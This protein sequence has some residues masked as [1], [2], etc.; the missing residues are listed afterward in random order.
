DKGYLFSMHEPRDA[1]TWLVAFDNP[2]DKATLRWEITVDDDLTAVANGN[3]IEMN[4][5][6]NNKNKW[7]FE[8]DQ[9]I[10]TYLMALD[11]GDYET[12]E[13]Q[14]TTGIPITHYIE[15]GTLDRANDTF[16][17]TP[18]VIDFFSDLFAEYPFDRYGNAVVPLGGLAM[19]HTTITSFGRPLVGDPDGALIN[20]HEIGHHW[21]GNW[22]TLSEWP[23][24]WLNE[25]FTSYSEVL[26]WEHLHGEEGRLEYLDYQRLVYM[27]EKEDEGTYP[28]YDPDDLFG[29][30]IYEKGSLVVDML[31]VVMGD[32][33]FFTTLRDWM[34]EYGGQNASTP[35][36]QALA[37]VEYGHSLDWFFDQWVYG[38]GQPSY[39]W[40]VSE[41]TIADGTVQLDFAI[42][43]TGNELFAMPMEL[44]WTDE[45]YETVTE[46]VWVS[47]AEQTFSF[48][49]TGNTS[50]HAFDPNQMV[51]RDEMLF[52]DELVDAELVCTPAVVDEDVDEE[53][54]RQCSCVSG[55]WQ[56]AVWLPLSLA[57]VFRRR[58]HP[59]TA[60]AE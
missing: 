32:E 33:A 2:A 50:D 26:W 29:S 57:F 9:P 49:V 15:P 58:C 52:V 22:V 46:E 31:R 19:E 24:I 59:W 27:W 25:G 12:I 23:E 8:L 17:N 41:Q 45:H 4:P 53:A 30:T 28:L 21:F 39:E 42:R 18:E 13:Q 14:T 16:G 37:E 11:A 7:I 36:L 47:E 43:Q 6:E 55:G 35:D 34:A 54:P 60:S 56:S 38:A 1:R 10:P 44:V 51:L 5:V 40:S 20:V 48:C 3:L